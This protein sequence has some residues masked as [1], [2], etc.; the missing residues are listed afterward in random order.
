MI[1]KQIGYIGLGKMGEAQVLRLLLRGWKV[2]VYNRSQGPREKVAKE[3]AVSFDSSELMVTKLPHPRTVWIMTS[4]QAVDEVL[5][6]I[7]PFLEKGDTVIDGGNS[8]YRETMRRA[9]EMEEKGINYLDC[10]VSGGPGGARFGA[11]LMIGGRESVAKKYEDLWTDLAMERGWQYVGP[12]GAGH[13]VKM[14]HNGIEYGMMQ[15]IAEGFDLLRHSKEF[16]D[17][18]ILRISDLYQHGSVITSRLVGWLHDAF[19]KFGEALPNI[20]GRASASGEG[21]W[22]V[23]AGKREGIPMPI[24]EGSV[25]VRRDTQEKPSYQGKVLSAMRGEFGHHPV[26][27]ESDEPPIL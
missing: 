22:T 9:K 21:G 2:L 24:I 4:H 12:S 25:V 23:E 13:F 27:K 8:P 7:T 15:A 10:G 16:P 20:S 26:A 5:H 11:C 19:G 14:V 18:D 6:N 17:L 1:H 3:G